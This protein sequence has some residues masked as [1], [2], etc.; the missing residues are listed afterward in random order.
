MTFDGAPLP[1][2]VPFGLLTHAGQCQSKSFV[3][4]GSTATALGFVRFEWSFVC[5]VPD[6]QTFSRPFRERGPTPKS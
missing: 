5:L 2:H 3:S 6:L 4:C 1:A